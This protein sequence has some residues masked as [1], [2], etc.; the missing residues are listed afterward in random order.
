MTLNPIEPERKSKAVRII[1]SIVLSL[2][3]ILTAIFLALF[4]YYLWQI[5]YGA[6]EKLARDFR[7]FESGKFTL[8]DGANQAGPKIPR[9]S[10]VMS[11]KI[12][13]PPAI[14]KAKSPFSLS[15]ISLAPILKRVIRFSIK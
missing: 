3:G 10:T 11:E 5:K 6:P 14:P 4:V 2:L 1:L 13:R 9:I 8:I 7:K 15:L 12:I